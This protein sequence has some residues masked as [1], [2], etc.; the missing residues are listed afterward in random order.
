ME[1][2]RHNHLIGKAAEK[3]ASKVNL[4]IVDPSYFSTPKRRE[5]LK[6]AKEMGD[7]VVNDHDYEDDGDND[8]D[9]YDEDDEDE[10]DENNPLRDPELDLLNDQ[11]NLN[12]IRNGSNLIDVVHVVDENNNHHI[13]YSH[14]CTSINSNIN[15][16]N[17]NNNLVSNYHDNINNYNN[18]HH[19]NNIN[20]NS[21]DSSSKNNSSKSINMN[22]KNKNNNDSNNYESF[23]NSNNNSNNNSDKNN[24]NSSGEFDDDLY[25]TNLIKE[26]LKNK[27]N[28]Y[29]N[30][31]I[32]SA[33]YV[34]LTSK[35]YPMRP[36]EYSIEH[37]VEHSLGRCSDHSWSNSTDHF[38]EHSAECSVDLSSSPTNL[39]ETE[40]YDS[41]ENDNKVIIPILYHRESTKERPTEI[42]EKIIVTDLT[43]NKRN[44]N[45]D[46]KSQKERN[47][48]I[49]EKE[50]EFN[51]NFISHNFLEREREREKEKLLEA[52]Y[53][54]STGTVGCVC[55]LHG[56]V[57]A[58]T[59]TGG[60]TNKMAGRVGTYSLF[61]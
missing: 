21:G 37:S 26:N 60:L 55:M 9:K 45:N 43:E 30:H 13:K 10:D 46:Q 2:T 32:H 17:E 29:A 51:V 6:R 33:Y 12:L 1:H 15:N 22:N 41:G 59:S 38:V 23:N 5:Q 42:I 27:N 11:N 61:F 49:K 39:T 34:P 18:N 54:G 52:F 58:A 53:P 25:I 28:G 20:N 4:D 7:A 35:E 40:D 14:N 3:L 47:D 56:H 57:A 36:I 44:Y 48:K 8:K 16:E 19:L 24:D 31:D 50:K